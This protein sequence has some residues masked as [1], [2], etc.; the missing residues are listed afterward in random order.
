[1]NARLRDRVAGAPITWGVCEVPGWGH[2]MFPERVFAD[3]RDLGLGATELGPK[4]YLSPGDPSAIRAL[5]EAFGMRL[6]AAFVPVVL[7]DPERLEDELARVRARAADLAASGASVLVLAVSTGREGYE[8]SDVIDAQGWRTLGWALD[9]AAE[10]ASEEGVLATVHPHH[11]TMVETPEEVDRVLE[12]SDISLCLDTGHLVVGGGDPASIATLAADRVGHVHLKD[13]DAEVAGR[14]RSGAL[15]YRDAVAGGMFRRLGEG[16]ANVADT[17]RILEGGG[18]TGWHVLEQDAVL[19]AE[20][21][22]GVGPVE[23][24][25]ASLAFLERLWEQI[26]SD[27][28]LRSAVQGRA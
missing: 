23:D 6:V 9:R 19:P 18:Y 10:V 12:L 3:M 20:P 24:A 5:L 2:Q 17:V 28:D 26:A 14:V 27:G 8:G 15:G 11:G 22:V 13:V 21:E 16:D 25:R 4:G 7:H 1:V